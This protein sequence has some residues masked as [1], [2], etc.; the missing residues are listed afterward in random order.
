[1][2]TKA[3][4]KRWDD[5]HAAYAKAAEALQEYEIELS[6]KYGHR[7]DRTWLSTGQR[8]KLDKL[9]ERRDKIGEKIIDLIVRVSPRGEDWLH[10]VPSFW[11]REELT[12]EDA[13]R[14]KNEPLSVVVPGAYGYPDGYMKERREQMNLVHFE[15][16]AD[17][18]AYAR[19]GH[20]LYYKAPMDR[21]ATRFIPSDGERAPYTYV[22]QA[23]TLKMYPPGSVG[24]GRQRTSDPFTADSGHLD[25]FSHAAEEETV[26]EEAEEPTLMSEGPTKDFE[27]FLDEAVILV[28]GEASSVIDPYAEEVHVAI[29]FNVTG[30]GPHVGAIYADQNRF[31]A[32]SDEALQGAHELLEEWEE[33]HYPDADAEHRTET[34]DGRTWT[35]PARE[36][37]DAIYGRKAEEF[38]DV[39]GDDEE[40]EEETEEDEGTVDDPDY[41]I[42]GIYD[43]G[44]ISDEYGYDDEDKA[45]REAE[46]LANSSLFE[47]DYVRVIT[48]D[49]EL[50]WD[51]REDS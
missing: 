15:S 23:R 34:F 20:P 39:E 8:N 35:L 27:K 43:N 17:V 48:R 14:P 24:R 46:K 49:G 6:V 9:R 1:M 4:K 30:Y 28:A 21:N 29:V 37:A 41:V 42:Q 38:I 33:E 44:T 2:A 47:G 40:A 26:G 19:E 45:V 12:W 5:L 36:F 10:G 3:D 32:G 16:W 18:L 25:R 11:L 51:S 13:I 31:H 50:V 7:F 22:V